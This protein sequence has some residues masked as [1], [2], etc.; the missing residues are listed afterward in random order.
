REARTARRRASWAASAPRIGRGSRPRDAAPAG[1]ARLRRPDRSGGGESLGMRRTSRSVSFPE[2]IV[3]QDP[4]PGA[5][6]AFDTDRSRC[7]FQRV[8]LR[9]DT[10]LVVSG[11]GMNGVLMEVG[12]LHRL[13]ESPFWPSG[14]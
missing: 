1:S 8:T 14:G 12:F 3:T 4:A 10:A 11:G 9:R 13:R 6:A 2:A 7:Y 5:T